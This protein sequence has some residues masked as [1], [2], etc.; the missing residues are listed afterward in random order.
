MQTWVKRELSSVDLG[1]VRREV[2][3]RK[4]VDDLSRNPGRSFNEACRMPADK[5][6][7]YRFFSNEAVEPERI[8]EAHYQQTRRRIE[9]QQRV[10][11]VQ[12]TTSLDYSSH[13]QAKGLGPLEAGGATGL[14]V[15]SGLALTEE[16]E[17]LGLVH[18][19]SWARD[20]EQVGKRHRRRERAWQTKESYKWQRTV[21]AVVAG[22]PEG[23]Q[24]II[25]GDRE[26]DVYGLLASPR[27]AGVDVLVR[28]AQNR[29][30]QAESG[31]LHDQLGKGPAAGQL[32]V[33]VGRAQERPARSAMCEVRYRQVTLTPPAAADA[34]VP[35]VPVVV[36][37]VAITERHPPKAE[38]ALRWVLL[39][40]WPIT[41]LE[42]AIQCALWYSRRWLVERYHYVLKSGC[43]IE[44]SQLQ[45]RQRLER[46]EAVYAIIAWR[47]L[48]LT[49]QA[50]LRPDQ[51]CDEVL[52]P[53]EWQV[54]YAHHHQQLPSPTASAP[55]LGEA[56][57]WVA[58]LGGYWGRKQDAPPGV[59][60]LWRGL[61][62]L[63][64]MVE[65]FTL[66]ASLLQP[67]QTCG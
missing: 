43:R 59:K 42:D 2:R 27:P 64:G 26:C 39:A 31:L 11:V 63:H 25:I 60:V 29:K 56:M 21:E 7:S 18:Q 6:A 15:H 38:R 53:Q 4:L 55:S 33:E 13:K 23:K 41:S 10:L 20:P 65:G 40:S 44:A 54:L 34:G 52:S 12:D 14:F 3:L 58:K 46:L 51:P 1:D 36:W 19:Q 66:A 37:A 32:M 57:E 9:S 67:G 48:A 47:L 22:Q 61:M 30:L 28:S 50:R 62:R 35:K 17:P 24:F 16:G 45:T 8:L 5:K 49:Y